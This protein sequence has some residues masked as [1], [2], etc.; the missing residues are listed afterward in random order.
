MLRYYYKQD[1]IV[2]EFVSRMIPYGWPR[3]FGPCQTIGGPTN[4]TN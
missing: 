4:Q 1:G 2:A 3:G